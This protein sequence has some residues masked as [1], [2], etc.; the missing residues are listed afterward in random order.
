MKFSAFSSEG[1]LLLDK[2]YYSVGGG[3]IH[4]EHTAEHTSDEHSTENSAL[5]STPYPFTSAKELLALCQTHQ[6]SISSI[7]LANECAS[8]NKKNISEEILSIWNV[9]QASVKNGCQS[10]GCLLYTSPSPRDRG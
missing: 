7:M 4:D 9:M 2:T 8:R 3:F 1:Q 10:S 5:P 6:Q